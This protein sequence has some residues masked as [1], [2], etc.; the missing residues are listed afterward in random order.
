MGAASIR[1]LGKSWAVWRVTDAASALYAK[2]MPIEW[3]PNE[4]TCEAR[5]INLARTDAQRCWKK[6][7]PKM[8]PNYL[9]TLPTG[10]PSP[11]QAMYWTATCRCRV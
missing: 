10:S 4:L 5:T 3:R 6:P 9:P 1:A 2:G 7:G 11:S 8:K